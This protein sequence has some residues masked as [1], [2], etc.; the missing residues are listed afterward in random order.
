MHILYGT[1]GCHLCED[2][3]ALLTQA[4]I[5]FNTI[6]IIDDALLLDSYGQHIPVFKTDVGVCYWPF[7]IAQIKQIIES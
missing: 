2:A 7:N 1:L 5:P 3:E 6:D 4:D